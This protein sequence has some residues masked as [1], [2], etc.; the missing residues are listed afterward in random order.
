[1]SDAKPLKHLI[2]A[3]FEAGGC[4][5]GSFHISQMEIIEF[6]LIVLDI[7]SNTIIDQF[8]TYVRPTMNP[9]L[10]D[11]CTELTG[12]TQAQVAKA[13]LFKDVIKDAELFI[14]KYPNSALICD[15][16]WDFRDIIPTQIKR[17][18]ITIGCEFDQKIKKYINIKREFIRK[19]ITKDQR[20]ERGYRLLVMLEMLKLEPIGVLHSGI[21]DSKNIMQIVQQMIK[22]NHY[23]KIK[24]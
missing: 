13:P 12:I 22:D 10:S 4:E 7:E 21:D 1:M 8:H 16:D 19:Y 23:F 11:F 2:V 9:I 18:S 5:K 14:A 3:D 15:G 6:P 17:E 20:T 24:K